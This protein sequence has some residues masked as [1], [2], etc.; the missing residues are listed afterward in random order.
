MGG[1]PAEKILFTLPVPEPKELL[2]GIRAKHPDVEIV[3]V[4][5]KWPFSKD[6]AAVDESWFTYI[7]NIHSLIIV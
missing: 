6:D 3:Y 4:E 5:R 1:G 2:D 7:L